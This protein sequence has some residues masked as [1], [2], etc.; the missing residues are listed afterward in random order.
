[1]ELYNYQKN[2]IEQIELLFKSKRKVLLQL[3][4][5]A[6]KTIV[7]SFLAKDFVKENNKRVLILCHRE[8]LIGQNSDKL[9]AIGATVE[10][11]RAENNKALHNSQVYVA[12]EKTAE[13]RLIKDPNFF[14]NVGLVIADECHE[15]RYEKIFKY[16]PNAKILGVTATPTH[17][18][19]HIF[20]KCNYCDNVTDTLDNCHNEEMQ[21]WTRPFTFSEIYEDIVSTVQV[22]D[23]IDNG[24]LVQDISF[25]RTPEKI[26][27]LKIDKSGEY[28]GA[29]L[30]D[31]YHNKEQ[32][33]NVLLNY[34]EICEGKKTIIFTSSTKVNVM[35]LEQFKG[36]NVRSY[37]SINNNVSERAG[38]VEWF[39]SNPDA[40]LI[41]T[42]V[43][44]TGFDVRDVQAIIVN[45]ATQS[46]ALWLQMVGRGG[47][48]TRG[49]EIYKDNFIVIDGG[50]NIDRFGQWSDNKDWRNI[51]FNGLSKPKAKSEPIDDVK[52]CFTCGALIPKTAIECPV[53]GAVEEI[54]NP[55]EQKVGFDVA[56]IISKVPIPTPA[57][58]IA[59]TKRNNESR[60]FAWRIL[61][62]Q[63]VDLF[64][65]YSIPK[66]QYLSKGEKR[67][68]QIIKLNYFHIQGSDLESGVRRTIKYLENKVANKLNL[69]YGISTNDE[70]VLLNE[71]YN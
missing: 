52:E 32:S 28:T 14:Q 12:M 2:A 35:L 4:T 48:C 55:T 7:F 24:T 6:G 44:T 38:I 37:D 18:K 22:Q 10:T 40:I 9:I 5:G 61:I 15:L 13:N 42:G 21:E 68:A 45:R 64:T 50:G 56:T 17:T 26:N 3:P 20:F 47:R 36:Y 60:D 8:E 59:Y 49:A 29:S 46:L 23:L 19:R 67:I 30:L 33:F 34:K 39:K 63:I 58:I 62:G 70:P 1:M 57:K 31:V 51:F 65:I 16:F 66:E 27:D 53:C 54:K 69:K 43:F 71:G 11:I 41:N 25:V